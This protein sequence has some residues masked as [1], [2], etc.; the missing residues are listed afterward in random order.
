M[1]NINLKEDQ[2]STK[3]QGFEPA[4]IDPGADRQL[5]AKHRAL[6]ASGDYPTVS[7][8]LIPTLGPELVRAS[9]VRAGD[10]VLD[11]AAGSGNAAIAAAGAIVTAS[12]LTPELFA[13]A[14]HRR[15]NVGSR[16]NGWRPTRR[17]CRLRTTVS[18]S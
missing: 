13:R 7:A 18:T 4:A 2:M 9:G 1:P 6:W 14:A 16:W 10:R 5:K 17:R 8:E 15:R 12:D 3:E 11:V